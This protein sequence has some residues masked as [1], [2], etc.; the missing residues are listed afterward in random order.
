MSLS[1]ELQKRVD[2]ACETFVDEI[3][4]CLKI[5]SKLHEMDADQRLFALETEI[6]P[7]IDDIINHDPTEQTPFQFFHQ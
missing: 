2:K 4:E 5:N 3:N 1:L 7:V 6:L